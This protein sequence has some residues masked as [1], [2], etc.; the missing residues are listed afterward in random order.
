MLKRKTVDFQGTSLTIQSFKNEEVSD[1]ENANDA[2]DGASDE[3]DEDDIKGGSCNSHDS[4]KEN[5][6]S[7]ETKCENDRSESDG[8]EN[9]DDSAAEAGGEEET[10]SIDGDE[11]PER[12][13]DEDLSQTNI[14]LNRSDC[15][16][17]HAVK[18]VSSD[19]YCSLE[20]VDVGSD[21]QRAEADPTEG[22]TELPESHSKD[23]GG[24]FSETD[25]ENLS[26]EE[27]RN[28]NTPNQ[29]APSVEDKEETLLPAEELEDPTSV[30][31]EICKDNTILPPELDTG[32][33]KLSS[34]KVKLLKVLSDAQLLG[35]SVM[36][37]GTTFDADKGKVILAGTTDNIMTA[38]L[39]L[40]EKAFSMSNFRVEMR[41]QTSELLFM[42]RGAEWLEREFQQRQI[43]AVLYQRDNSI[44]MVALDDNSYEVA[45]KAL[46][47][48][49]ADRVIPFQ[50]DHLEYLRSAA[51]KKSME[52]FCA[53]EIVQICVDFD[54]SKITVEGHADSVR[55]ISENISA[56]LKTNSKVTK[57]IKLRK[58]SL[59][60]LKERKDA[61]SKT[62]REEVL[63]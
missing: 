57:S 44:N 45:T 61:V 47:E 51:W 19:E 34:E 3:S 8:E 6:S 4:K 16:P 2:D 39:Y 49:L 58:G 54:S 9:A 17:S 25:E 21:T 12:L 52:E 36:Q 35:E 14:E 1:E 46:Q 63:K 41:K 32:E 7:C 60:L 13:S 37:V 30:S 59:R 23:D 43:N 18:D 62:V 53:K 22:R 20:E 29:P 27:Q 42:V 50:D 33:V 40:Y 11:H 28:E 38:K 31:T 5:E 56:L 48:I 24:N 10:G 26:E 55:S 15:H